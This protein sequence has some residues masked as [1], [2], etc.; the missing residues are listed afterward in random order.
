MIGFVKRMTTDEL[1]EALELGAVDIYAEIKLEIRGRINEAGQ[2]AGLQE[3]REANQAPAPGPRKRELSEAARKR[4]GD[5]Q[6][7]RWAKHKKHQAKK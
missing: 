1:I 6:R 5:A 3:F 2:K 4:I 7:R